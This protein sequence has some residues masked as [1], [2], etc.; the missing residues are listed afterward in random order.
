M[1]AMYVLATEAA[2]EERTSL[3]HQTGKFETMP[4]RFLAVDNLAWTNVI[5][6]SSA[7]TFICKGA[8]VHM[9]YVFSMVHSN[10]N[11]NNVERNNNNNN[12]K[13]DNNNNVL[14][15]LKRVMN[16]NQNLKCFMDIYTKADLDFWLM[17]IKHSLIQSW[18]TQH[19]DKGDYVDILFVYNIFKRFNTW[20]EIGL[21]SMRLRLI[22]TFDIVEKLGEV[23][24]Q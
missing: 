9:A 14:Y 15:I 13:R 21:K 2:A 1:D 12:N 18:K 5:W 20:V 4:M 22:H 7:T 8:L 10:N 17:C 11:N 19:P 24:T 6:T 3:L 23:P 16:L